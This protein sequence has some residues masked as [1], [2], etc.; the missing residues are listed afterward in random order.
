MMITSE[1][2]MAAE[3]LAVSVRMLLE[4]VGFGEK[5]AVRPLDKPDA[6]RLTGPVNP[7]RGVMV[8]ADCM[9]APW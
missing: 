8:I 2:V 4:V 5:E 3:L 9:E 7:V 6:V 1:F